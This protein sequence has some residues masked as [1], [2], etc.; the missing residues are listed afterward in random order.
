MNSPF[1]ASWDKKTSSSAIFTGVISLF[2]ARRKKNA[3]PSSSWNMNWK[4]TIK[5]LIFLLGKEVN[6]SDTHLFRLIRD[7]E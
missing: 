4:Y 7:K 2:E 3:L 1:L 5:F 6:I